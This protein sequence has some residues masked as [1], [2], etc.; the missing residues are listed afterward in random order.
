M[1]DL[2]EELISVLGKVCFKTSSL[3]SQFQG[4]FSF[5]LFFIFLNIVR[6][7]DNDALVVDV[8]LFIFFI[9]GVILVVGFRVRCEEVCVEFVGRICFLFRF[10]YSYILVSFVND[11]KQCNSWVS[12]LELDGSLY[13]LGRKGKFF[14]DC[15]FGF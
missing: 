9:L 12:L 10:F 2:E 1:E 13:V 5:I 15:D 6:L 3:K 14:C 8:C 4:F 11:Y 7:D